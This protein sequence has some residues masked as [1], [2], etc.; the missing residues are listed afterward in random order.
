MRKTC[1]VECT[2][3]LGKADTADTE[4]NHRKPA[5]NHNVSDLQTYHS[6][7][8]YMP[9]FWYLEAIHRSTSLHQKVLQVNHHRAVR[10]AHL[11]A[12]SKNT[13]AHLFDTVS[14]SRNVCLL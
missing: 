1:S 11:S 4:M 6:N 2:T 10:H 5:A 7:E 14:A 9:L 13:R 8:W 3:T 12:T